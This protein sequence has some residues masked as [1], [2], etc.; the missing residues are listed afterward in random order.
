MS[1]TSACVSSVLA[2]GPMSQPSA[3]PAA[4]RGLASGPTTKAPANT[5]VEVPGGRVACA[6]N[7]SAMP[8]RKMT[9]GSAGRGPKAP[10][11]ALPAKAANSARGPGTP[12]TPMPPTTCPFLKI[13]TPPPLT[14]PGSLSKTS[15][16]P[17]VMPSPHPV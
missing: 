7:G 2:N 11:G 4:A 15:A 9:P 3:T 1:V 8:S 12:V 5:P 14:A 13:G 17:V 10:L 6:T 16:L